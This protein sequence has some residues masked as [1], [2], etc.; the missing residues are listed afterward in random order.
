MFY[1]TDPLVL[2]RHNAV[3]V[4]AN[5][6]W[7]AMPTSMATNMGITTTC[8]TAVTLCAQ[9]AKRGDYLQI[10]ATGLGK[11]TPN[12]DPGA[13]VLPTGSVAPINGNPL[14]ETVGMPTVMIGGQPATVVFSGLGP[15]FAGLYQVDVQIPAN[16]SPGDDVPISISLAG[17]TDSD[18]IAIQ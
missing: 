16:I 13:A 12:G 11:A 8:S 10:Y 4:T 17:R 3:A 9:P 14:Y 18:T 15:G 7:I 6:A 5:T 1:Y 2:T